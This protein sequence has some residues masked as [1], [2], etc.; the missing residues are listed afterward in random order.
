MESNGYSW[1]DNN[2]NNRDLMPLLTDYELNAI[3]LRVWV[4]P[5]NSG[6]NGWCD[7][8]DLVNKSKLADAENLDIMICIHYSDWWAD[9]SNQTK[10]AAWVGLSAVSYT[11]LT[12]PTKRIV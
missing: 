3:R 10:P 2:G 11:H 12:L 6:A 7:I 1:K 9:P 8:D 4:N 5:N